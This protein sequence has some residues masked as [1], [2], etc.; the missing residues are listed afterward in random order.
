[1]QH[2][3]TV[4][5]LVQIARDGAAFYGQAIDKVEDPN[6]RSIFARMAG[7]KQKIIDSLSANLRLH[8]EETP[9][10][11]TVAGRIRQ[12]Y[13]DLLASLS[14]QD[15]RIYVSQLEE[16]EDRLLHH[17]ERAMEDVEDP[18]VR[19]LL[20]TH[21]PQVRACHEEMRALKQEMK[22]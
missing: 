19:A 6:I 3:N 21:M 16:T 2:A 5:E 8:D 13:A 12:G 9:E 11:G 14:S 17:F 22:D 18:A 10:N 1:M 4:R 20:Q 15:A 7:H